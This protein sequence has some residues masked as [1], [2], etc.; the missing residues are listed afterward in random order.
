MNEIRSVYD[1][2]ATAHVF[3]GL[4][5]RMLEEVAG[6]GVLS[7]A[8]ARTVVCRAGAPAGT[9][10]VIREGRVGIQIAAPGRGAITVATRGPGDA[11]EWSWLFPPFR[12]HFDAITLEPVRLIELDG[13]CLRGKCDR[14][15]DL[16]YQLMRR[17]AQIA[18]D[19]LQATRM[20]LLDV[21]G[22]VAS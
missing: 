10:N 1:L 2:L 5:Q 7:R 17:F 11:V 9:F 19:D 21:Y 6:C 12:W 8:E 4:P 18:I 22:H 16:G 3:A 13:V 20:Q 15:A 14:N